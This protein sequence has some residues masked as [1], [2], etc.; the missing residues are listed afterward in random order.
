[1][2]WSSALA[3]QE[4]EVHPI[5]SVVPF[6]EG[7]AGNAEVTTGSRSVL[8]R[9]GFIADHPFEPQAGVLGEG[10]EF[11]LLAPPCVPIKEGDGRHEVAIHFPYMGCEHKDESYADNSPHSTNEGVLPMYL[12]FFKKWQE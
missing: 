4:P 11:C 12:I 1:M 8:S 7:F 10:E 5:K 2:L 6:V 9:L 3:L